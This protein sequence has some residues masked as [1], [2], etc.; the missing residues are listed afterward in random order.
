MQEK[1][2]GFKALLFIPVYG[3]WFLFIQ[4]IA[5]FKS[6]KLKW[7]RTDRGEHD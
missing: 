3:L 1:K 4:L 7:I 2:E 6:G 5:I